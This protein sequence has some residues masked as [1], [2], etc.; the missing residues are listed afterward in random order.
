MRSQFVVEVPLLMKSQ[1]VLYSLL[2]GEH[3]IA[4]VFV[5]YALL[6]SGRC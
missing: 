3:P 6:Q 5:R 4:A 1:S 2:T